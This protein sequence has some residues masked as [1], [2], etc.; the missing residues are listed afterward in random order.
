MEASVKD[1]NTDVVIYTDGSTDGNKNRGGAGLYIQDRKTQ[2]EVKL[3]FAA[4]AIF[5]SY[6]AEGVA[7]LRAM[8]WLEEN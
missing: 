6:G 5:S 1:T 7:L 4:G 2:E 8:E 3:S